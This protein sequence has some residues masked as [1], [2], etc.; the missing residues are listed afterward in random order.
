MPTTEQVEGLIRQITEFKDQDVSH[1]E[2]GTVGGFQQAQDL[3]ASIA[4]YLLK[5]LDAIRDVIGYADD[6]TL[7]YVLEEIR[8]LGRQLG[9]IIQEL[10]KVAA[11]GVHTDRFPGQRDSHLRSFT[12]RVENFRRTFQPYEAA[13]RT[14]RLERMFDPAHV[15]GVIGETEKRLQQVDGLLSQANKALEN[16]QT[17][18]MAKAVG[19][20]ASSFAKL[21][22]AHARREL[23]W[24]VAFLVAGGLTLS[25]VGYVVFCEWTVED[26]PEIVA[27]ITRKLLLIST[28]AVFM[29]IT[30]AK[31]NLE[32]NLRI[33]YDHRETVLEQY[34]TFETAIG[35]D[36]PSKNQFRLEIAKYIFS[37]PITGYIAQDSGAEINVN[38]IVGMIERVTGKGAA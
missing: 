17:K 35:D 5:L 11:A 34:R 31:Y 25:A 16:V 14:A 36:V 38:P 22:D 2:F 19:T 13:I 4:E 23:C 27:A 15:T 24:F 28:P 12:E 21:R 9:S 37:D 29:R 10:E 6:A 1:P 7:D 30:L 18:A 26:V 20:A 33:I 32:R 8:Q 3:K